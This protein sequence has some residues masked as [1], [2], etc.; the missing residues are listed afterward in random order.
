MAAKKISL[1]TTIT[2]S[3]KGQVVIPREMR[4]SVNLHEGER[5]LIRVREDNVIELIPLKR[6]VEELFSIFGENFEK[7]RIEDD[8]LIRQ[9]FLNRNSNDSH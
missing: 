3:S 5:M 2:L 4:D 7:N 1:E 9:H 6:N 8:E